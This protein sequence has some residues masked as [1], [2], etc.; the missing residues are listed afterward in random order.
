M[1][2]KVV[3]E[4]IVCVCVTKL[5]MTKLCVKGCVCDEAVCVTKL[6]VCDKVVFERDG[7]T[8]SV[9]VTKCY[10]CHGNEGRLDQVLACHAK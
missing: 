10:T 1:C 2:D 9:D 3:Y 8:C 7:L 6:R 5:W 4:R